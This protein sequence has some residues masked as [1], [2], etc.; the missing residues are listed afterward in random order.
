MSAKTNTECVS[1]PEQP[2]K[3]A[4]HGNGKRPRVQDVECVMIAR[5]DAQR[6]LH[7]RREQRREGK[8]VQPTPAGCESQITHYD[9][10][11]VAADAVVD[12]R[13]YRKAEDVADVVRA[14]HC[15]GQP[16]RDAH[17][18]LVQRQRAVFEQP[19][20]EVAGHEAPLPEA[21]GRERGGRGEDEPVHQAP[22]LAL[23]D[24][25]GHEAMHEVVERLLLPH[26]RDQRHLPLVVVRHERKRR[27]I[28]PAAGEHRVHA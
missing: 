26:A 2:R 8:R 10:A 1:H 12:P 21:C 11:S 18:L 28:E 15:W 24:A 16:R 17:D 6:A 13:R 14:L 25:N 23:R 22:P 9:Q 19:F 4:M 20:G 5:G 7:Q 27:G 3:L